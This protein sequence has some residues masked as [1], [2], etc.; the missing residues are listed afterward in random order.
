MKGAWIGVIALVLAASPLAGAAPG[1]VEWTSPGGDAGKTHFSPL[2]DINPGNVARLGL[3]WQA[4][5]GTNRVLEATPVMVDGVLYTSGVAGRVYA[6]D[7]ATGR[8]LWAFEPPI[9][10][11]VNRW[12]CCDMA[13]R[14]VA[15]ADGRVYVGA[16]D[17]WLY[18]LDARTGRVV[19]KV[20]SI[21]DHRRGMSSTGAPEIA[22]DV[23]V[24]GNAGSDYD[25]RGY[26]TAY[27]R[28]TGALRWRFHTTPANPALGPQDNPELDAAVKTWD[29]A[30][31]WDM[32][33]GG[34]PWDAIAYDR[35]T[36]LVLV[37]TGNAEPYS[38]TLRSPR[39]GHN[40][41]VSSIVAIDARTGRMAWFYQESPEDQWDYDAT[42]PMILTHLTIDGQNRAV[43]LHAPKNGFF[44]ALDRRTGQV[45]RA[46]PVVRVNWARRIDP[47]TGVPE[48]DPA[49]DISAGPKIVFPATPGARNWHPGSYDPAT[50][51]WYGAMLDMGNLI[52]VPP[53]PK[54]HMAKGL[55]TGAALIF[56][57]DLAQA[58][59]TL[60]PQ[61]QAAVRALPAWQQV[62]ANPAQ[63]DIRAIDPLT[64]R[65][66][67]SVPTAGWQDRAGVLTTAAGLVIHGS[68]TGELRVLDAHTGALLTSIQTGS[69]I[70][71]APMTYRV[72]G[73]QYIAVL[74]AWGGGGYP[75][76]PRYAAAYQRGNIG[77]L[78][79]FRLDGGPVAL[80]PPLPPLE[81]AP[82]PPAQ[83]A[84]V[85]AGVIARGQALYFTVGCALCHANQP[86][87]ITPD[88][89][90][91]RPET[92]A[93]FRQIVLEGLLQPAGMPRW[94]DVLK[95]GDADAIH[96]WL[97]DSQA[98]VRADELAKQKQGLPLDAPSL[99][100]LSNY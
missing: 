44:Y 43:V 40:L 31:R 80:P 26:V 22:G 45:L 23:V 92:H 59:P 46:N 64:G 37:G 28:R 70:M 24:L 36:G 41:Y 57:A 88:L 77:R 11:Q 74:A 32:G 8:E 16:L 34:S 71:A 84:G 65:T 78:L 54:P 86:R 7:A 93:A 73:V 25:A 58:L 33:A 49:A 21:E 75:Y 81:V 5:L 60:P 27:D 19:W 100:I 38:L 9:D 94:D 63:A 47:K 1:D 79:V 17:G 76:V 87:S 10:M 30:S 18:A 35:E 2:T 91:M 97:I 61:V 6:F 14:G 56:T 96:A 51:L 83:A 67:W 68:V 85:T 20:D 99:A 82:P 62:Q 55:N 39:G 52:F 29:P 72:G 3:A 48:L 4:E 12:V 66:I 98:H 90:R 95:P 69:S 50:G 53:G 15:V 89:R 42:A 13:N